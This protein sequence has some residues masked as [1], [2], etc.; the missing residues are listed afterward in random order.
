[1][2]IFAGIF[3]ARK[4]SKQQ[5]T[6][7]YHSRMNGTEEFLFG[8]FVFRFIISSIIFLLLLLSSALAAFKDNIARNA[9]SKT[10]LKCNTILRSAKF[11][12]KDIKKNKEETNPAALH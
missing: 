8:Y 6:K 3:S 7:D 9:H 12:R 1:M 2:V 11:K 5:R 4:C 10:L